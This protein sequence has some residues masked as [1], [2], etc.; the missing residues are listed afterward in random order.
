MGVYLLRACGFATVSHGKY[1]PKS[2]L[3]QPLES[4]FNMLPGSGVME[5][6]SVG[7]TMC[8]MS[9]PEVTE[10]VERNKNDQPLDLTNGQ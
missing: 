7:H 3:K 1:V 4:V 8:S 2:G 10:S 9:S 6:F 5:Q